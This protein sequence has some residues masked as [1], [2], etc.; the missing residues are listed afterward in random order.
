MLN[1]NSIFPAPNNQWKY[2]QEHKIA[3][4]YLGDNDRG[5]WVAVC[6]TPEGSGWM[7][8]SKVLT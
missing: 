2:P 3:I 8:K 1:K 7:M 5:C 6:K 4:N